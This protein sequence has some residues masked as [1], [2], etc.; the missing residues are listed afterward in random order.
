M[1]EHDIEKYLRERAKEKGGTAYKW[2]SPGNS[3]VPDRIVMLP[4]LP[5]L[6]VEL[7]APGKEPTALQLAQHH[8]LRKLGRHVM[9]IDSKEGVDRLMTDIEEGRFS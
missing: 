7:K 4:G 9:V 1:R 3:G 5:D 2:V 8:R 6:F